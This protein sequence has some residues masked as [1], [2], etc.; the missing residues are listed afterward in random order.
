MEVGGV[1]PVALAGENATAMGVAA[2]AMVVKMRK[3]CMV[4]SCPAD[5]WL[6]FILLFGGEQ[7]QWFFLFREQWNNDEYDAKNCS[8]CGALSLSPSS[9]VFMNLQIKFTDVEYHHVDLTKFLIRT[10]L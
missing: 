4:V 1:L 8:L 6:V 5:D 3:K 10:V 9:L 7:Q 2:A